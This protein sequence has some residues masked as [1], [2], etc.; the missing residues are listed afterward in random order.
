MKYS[1][2][3]PAFN[4]A[5]CIIDA[6]DSAVEAATNC[7]IVDEVEIIIVDDGSTDGTEKVIFGYIDTHPDVTIKYFRNKINMGVAVARNKACQKASGE[8][9][10][11]L[12]SD[13]KLTLDAFKIYERYMN[14][15]PDVVV[16]A[17]GGRD[18]DGNITVHVKDGDYINKDW[19]EYFEKDKFYD[20]EFQHLLKKSVDEEFPFEE[21]LNGGEG[22]KWY[23][24]NKK[25]YDKTVHTETVTR[26]YNTT[27]TDSL[28]RSKKNS[29]WLDNAVKI[30]KYRLSVMEE[31][32]RLYS[33]KGKDGLAMSYAILGG[34]YMRLGNKKAG[35]KYTKKAWKT[36]PAEPRAYR[37]ILLCL[38][39][40]K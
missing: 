17:F 22:V 6:I 31:D 26:Y 30:C 18:S 20:G 13:D 32:L 14:K 25:Y 16:F 11:D 37:N 36:D 4:R 1:V 35:L 33:P 23:L 21:G 38:G 12:D 15:Y 7:G 8:W 10:V 40:I 3:I 28:M 29:K 34:Y 39:L 27:N 19:K 5:Y 9:I 24:I 2:R